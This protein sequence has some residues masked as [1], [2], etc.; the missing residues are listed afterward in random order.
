LQ[1]P[2]FDALAIELLAYGYRKITYR[3][4]SCI[5]CGVWRIAQSV[6]CDGVNSDPC[7]PGCGGDVPVS[8]PLCWGFSRQSLPFAEKL[9][10]GFSP[11][12]LSWLNAQIDDDERD[13]RRVRKERA[14]GRR[15]NHVHNRGS[16]IGQIDPADFEDSKQNRRYAVL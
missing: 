12:A 16:K 2:A 6:L 10:A 4:L 13:L 3:E 7:C 8:P 5:H 14:L 11:S 9:R 1:T 15:G